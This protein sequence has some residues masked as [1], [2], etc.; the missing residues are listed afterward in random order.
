MRILTSAAICLA[1]LAGPASTSVSGLSLPTITLPT[2]TWPTLPNP[3][4][5]TLPTWPTLP[6]LPDIT[7][8]T[9]PTLPN[10]PDI[11]WPT[12]PTLPS[13]DDLNA[14]LAA[15]RE[16]VQEICPNVTLPEITFKDWTPS[17]HT[18]PTVPTVEEV[19]TKLAELK[20]K[21]QEHRQSLIETR[22]ALIEKHQAFVQQHQEWVKS[23]VDSVKE[24]SPFEFCQGLYE[25]S[26][27]LKAGTDYSE[28][29]L[30]G[31]T[32]KGTG[33]VNALFE[34]LAGVFAPGHSPG[35]V[36][37]TD[38]YSL[39]G[40]VLE[41]EIQS[42]GG[43]PGVDLDFF[44]VTG[45]ALLDSTVRL[46]LL[47]EFKPEAGETFDVLAADSIVFGDN[48]LLDQSKLAPWRGHFDLS[49]VGDAG[50]E[51]LRLTAV[52]NPEPSTV[53]M[54]VGA[55]ACLIGCAW[56]RRRSSGR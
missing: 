24:S 49:V 21:A 7:L 12:W 26:D 17:E 40:G 35:K 1:L 13:A 47:D 9:W 39:K 3:P 28:Y 54:L 32:L 42:D 41:L 5:I 52:P 55:A 4:H 44:D 10:P 25:L 53:A 38:G 29:V 8:P 14:K 15:L 45:T 22:Q 11:T 37:F 31:G 16:K 33:T 34:Q 18:W 51:I 46:L 43:V 56:R 23:V 20:A 2:F 50:R 27:V 6:D 30:N 36:V 19:K 48:F